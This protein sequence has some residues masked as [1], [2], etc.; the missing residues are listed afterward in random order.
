MV[1][2]LLALCQVAHASGGT[3]SFFPLRFERN[4]GQTESVAT[5]VARAP[6]YSVFLAPNG[7]TLRAGNSSVRMIFIGANPFAESVAL[8]PLDA[9]VHYMVGSA[10][11]WRTDLPSYGRLE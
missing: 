10:E 4:V 5:F 8:D 6:N 3:S 2:A 9:R 7:A 1:P 11:E